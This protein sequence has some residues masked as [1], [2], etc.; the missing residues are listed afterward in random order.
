MTVMKGRDAH[1][2]LDRVVEAV[3]RAASNGSDDAEEALDALGALHELREHLLTCEPLLIE[4]ARAGGASWA[5]LAP[6]LG[7]TSRQAAERRYLRLRPGSDSGLTREQRVQ[8]T[9]DERAGNRAVSAWAR[10]NASALRQIAGQASGA[11]GLDAAGRRRARA[12][13]DCLT[14]DD[15]GSL[16]DP[17]A[18]LHE[19]L[20]DGHAELAGRVEAVGRSVDRVRRETQD[21]RAGPP[22]DD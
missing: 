9:R 14:D 10:E 8:A 1:E 7:V 17:L 11:A 21:R 16:I 3:R 13:A 6:V 15:P 2:A 18:D 19:H 4:A 22:Q 5:T 20:V 12:L